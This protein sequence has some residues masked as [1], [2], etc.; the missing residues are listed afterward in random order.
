[1]DK[2]KEDIIGESKIESSKRDEMFTI[3]EGEVPLED[4]EFVEAEFRF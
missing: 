3:H 1:M 2:V 4:G